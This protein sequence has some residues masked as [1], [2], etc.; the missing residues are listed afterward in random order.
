MEW[1]GMGTG[2]TL[3]WSRVPQVASIT[4][5]HT[6]WMASPLASREYLI[7]AGPAWPP[8]P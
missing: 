4:W 2:S 3:P 5:S 7:R 8:S 6:I 1:T